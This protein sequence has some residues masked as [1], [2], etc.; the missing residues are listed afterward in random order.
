MGM[1]AILY[2]M[3]S[4]VW[5]NLESGHMGSILRA[6]PQ[7]LEGE[8]SRFDCMFLLGVSN[9]LSMQELLNDINRNDFL[10]GL[11]TRYLLNKS[12]WRTFAFCA[13]FCLLSGLWVAYFV[14]ETRGKPLENIDELFRYKEELA[15][16]EEKKRDIRKTLA[17]SCAAEPFIGL[18]RTP[19]NGFRS[20]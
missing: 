6:F 9:S 11:I 18:A 20:V 15:R 2:S 17:S 10:S 13:G 16:E 19:T 8:R 4:C 1:R 7:Y 3:Y 14:P 12:T 5:S